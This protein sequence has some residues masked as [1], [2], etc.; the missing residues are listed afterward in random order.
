[1]LLRKHGKNSERIISDT[2][3]QLFCEIKYRAPTGLVNCCN[4]ALHRCMIS[5]LYRPNDIVRFVC[6]DR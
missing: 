5:W 6:S 4:G 3:N 2:G 1:M